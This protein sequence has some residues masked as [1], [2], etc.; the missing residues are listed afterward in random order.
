[1]WVFWSKPFSCVL[2]RCEEG[3]WEGSV[4]SKEYAKLHMGCVA[5]VQFKFVL[6]GSF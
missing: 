2:P 6:E 3:L 5:S 4:R 1:M